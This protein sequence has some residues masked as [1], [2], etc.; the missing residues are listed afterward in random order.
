M[1]KALKQNCLRAFINP[2]PSLTVGL[3]PRFSHPLTQAV[4]TTALPRE[5]SF[6]ISRGE[7]LTVAASA[8]VAAAPLVL[9]M[10]AQVYCCPASFDRP[11]PSSN[12]QA[13]ACAAS[14]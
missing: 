12:R 3:M 2:E 14:A 7:L 13:S 4:L 6:S 10:A 9:T 5:I 8:R 11:A 1:K